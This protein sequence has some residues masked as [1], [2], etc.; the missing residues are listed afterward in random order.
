MAVLRRALQRETL[1][2]PEARMSLSSVCGGAQLTPLTMK[3]GQPTH[4]QGQSLDGIGRRLAWNEGGA[5]ILTG[6]GTIGVKR[7][8][9]WVYGYSPTSLLS[10]CLYEI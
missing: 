9:N 7:K 8:G 10:C 3:Q 5:L 4:W 1:C 2:G 6:G